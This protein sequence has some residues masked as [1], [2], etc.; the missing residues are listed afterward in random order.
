MKDK[1]LLK[2]KRKMTKLNKKKQKINAR[3][4]ELKLEKYNVQVE[5]DIKNMERI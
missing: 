4:E 1:R 3:I 2:I 5:M